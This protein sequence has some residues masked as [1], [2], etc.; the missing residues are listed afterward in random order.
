MEEFED[1]VMHQTHGFRLCVILL[2]RTPPRNKDYHEAIHIN[3]STNS[4][5][6]FMTSSSLAR[7]S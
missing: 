2:M 5:R 4:R 7:T 6:T 3:F 1:D